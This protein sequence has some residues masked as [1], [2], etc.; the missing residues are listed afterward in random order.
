MIA[1]LTAVMVIAS[2]ALPLILAQAILAL[3]FRLMKAPLRDR[4][5]AAAESASPPPLA[6]V[7]DVS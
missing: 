3:L 5:L 7:V 4:S 1:L 2:V 6:P